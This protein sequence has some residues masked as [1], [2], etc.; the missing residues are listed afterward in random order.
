MSHWTHFFFAKKDELDLEFLYLLALASLQNQ[1]LSQHLCMAMHGMI[2]SH[3][4]QMRFSL[5]PISS[6]LPSLDGFL[7]SFQLV[8]CF[9]FDAARELAL[10]DL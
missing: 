6:R 5:D 9:I 3:P 1:Q 8:S 2:A 10:L 4:R 7:S